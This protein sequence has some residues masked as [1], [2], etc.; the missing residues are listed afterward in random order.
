MIDIL[1]T[2]VFIIEKIIVKI[3]LSFYQVRSNDQ[4]LSSLLNQ[5][6]FHQINDEQETKSK[7]FAEVFYDFALS[8]ILEGVGG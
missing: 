1:L 4:N 8:H 7:L 6:I 5:F 3:L 2:L